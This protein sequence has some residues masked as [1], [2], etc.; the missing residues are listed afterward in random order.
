MTTKT[1]FFAPGRINIIGEHTDYSG[2]YVMPAPLAYGISFINVE[3]ADEWDIYSVSTGE[4]FSGVTSGK[5]T[6]S[7]QLMAFVKA[8][9]K[10]A[11]GQGLQ[12][13][14]LKGILESDLPTGSG[15]SSSTALTSVL[16]AAQYEINGWDLSRSE[17]M[18]LAQQTEINMGIQCGIMD[19]YCMWQGIREKAI[20]LDCS[21]LK[22]RVLDIH[23][24]GYQWMLLFSGVK[25]QILGSPYNERR[26]QLFEGIGLLEKMG[27]KQED[28]KTN[29]AGLLSNAMQIN[30]PVV[31]KRVRYVI[32]ENARVLEMEE[33]LHE[34]DAKRVMSILNEGQAGLKNDYEV[35]CD[36]ID[37]LVGSVMKYQP[38]IGIRMVGGG[39]G[40]ALIVFMPE[41]VDRK[42]L[43]EALYEYEG[44]TGKKGVIL[45]LK[46]GDPVGRI[47]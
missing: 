31:R 27:W 33:V 30:D 46:L 16:L 3:P 20:L 2:G 13:S 4:K 11:I 41:D 21:A 39:F 22:H 37:I 24:P 35:S 8:I 26:K 5:W 7:R 40:G 45:P 47:D 38:E 19:Q 28:L 34:K 36:E 14:P 1:G 44:Q 15:L 25:H 6:G 42:F 43:N 17:M 12:T 10:T 18:H 32:S 23:I 9:E 29:S